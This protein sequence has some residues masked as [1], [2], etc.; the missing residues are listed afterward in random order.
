MVVS[1]P[2]NRTIVSADRYLKGLMGIKD[3]IIDINHIYDIP[4][5]NSNQK[6]VIYSLDLKD[7][8]YFHAQ[9][10]CH[11]FDHEKKKYKKYIR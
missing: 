11:R 7:D 8:Y 6:L 3:Y 10:M 4:K 5:N 9:N 2:V 1:S